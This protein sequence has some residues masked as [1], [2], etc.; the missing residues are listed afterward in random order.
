MSLKPAW[1][2]QQDPGFLDKN[3][4]REQLLKTPTS[5]VANISTKAEAA[6]LRSE[7]D[8][9]TNYF[10]FV[11]DVSRRNFKSEFYKGI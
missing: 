7:H 2:T 11:Q 4:G 3:S 6:G 1:A 9:H 8:F 10:H 5:S